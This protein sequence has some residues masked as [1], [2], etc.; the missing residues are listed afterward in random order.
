MKTKSRKS[1]A[2]GSPAAIDSSAQA[3]GEYLATRSIYDVAVSPD[4]REVAFVTN[5]DGTAQLWKMPS[6]GGFP[7]QLT[8]D[9]TIRFNFLFGL[10]GTGLLRWSPDGQWIACLLDR[11]G[12]EFNRVVMI[13]GDGSE[14]VTLPWQEKEQCFLGAWTSDAKAFYY[15]SNRRDARFFDV[16]RWDAARGSTIVF[17]EDDQHYATSVPPRGGWLPVQRQTSHRRT[18]LVLVDLHSGS[19]VHATPWEGEFTIN[20]VGWR[21]DHTLV[22]EL[23]APDHE[24][25]QVALLKREGDLWRPKFLTQGRWDKSA[26]LGREGK[27]A[28]ILTNDD[29]RD[30]LTFAS[31]DGV[32]SARGISRQV[33]VPADGT[34]SY[35]RFSKD[36][37]SLFFVYGTPSKVEDLYRQDL[38][39]GKLHRLTDLS[40]PRVPS[41]A[42]LPARLVHYRSG[43]H[44]I[45][46]W[47]YLP[48]GKK[49]PPCLVWIHGGPKS[50]VRA[51][52]AP[53]LQFLASLGFAIWVPNHRGSTGYGESFAMAI[54]RNWGTVDL[55]D[56]KHGLSWLSRSGQVDSKRL[57]VMGGSYGGYATLRSVTELPRAWRCGIDIYGPSNLFTFLDSVPPS[58]KK[59]R[60]DWVGDPVK[61]RAQLIRQSPY[62]HLQRVRAPMLVIQGANDPR[63]V[64]AESDKVV[65]ALR[66]RRIPVEY[67]VFGDEGHGFSK[68][69][70]ELTAYGAV[71][72]FLAR[73]VPR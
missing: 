20:P 73:H 24:F 57:V 45:S 39:T 71:A 2:A 70:N 35:V 72:R 55:E 37:R 66:K 40:N 17:Q 63:V 3:L 1:S 53:R 7:V 5:L 25:Q 65:A 48:K 16:Y 13:C 46:S 31:L 61:D 28:A 47:L 9:R 4:G 33:N 49:K 64:K 6:T 8:H 15:S 59:F 56:L 12:D 52:Y 14:Q 30:R 67:L 22:V 54:D 69:E 27:L 34:L 26:L 36:A 58:W 41:S 19:A 18:D 23:R 29:G 10:F 32:L 60:A 38:P 42:L 43:K 44:T 50:Q 68:R 51:K 21:D 11:D 62:F